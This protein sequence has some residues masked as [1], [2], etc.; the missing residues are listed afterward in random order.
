MVA[1]ATCKFS[2]NLSHTFNHYCKPQSND[3]SFAHFNFKI[4]WIPYDQKNI[5]SIAT[6]FHLT[7]LVWK[8]RWKIMKMS[9]SIECHLS[10]ESFNCNTACQ[11]TRWHQKSNEIQRNNISSLYR[12]LES[13]WYHW[14]RQTTFYTNWLIRTFLTFHIQI[15]VY[16]KDLLLEQF[17]LIMRRWYEKH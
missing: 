15:L 9:I 4:E 11:S 5:F 2:H 16:H 17:F 3:K 6:I 7:A 1:L 8:K 10:Q 14:K 12:L 13:I